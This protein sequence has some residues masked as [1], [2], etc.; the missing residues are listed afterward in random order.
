[1]GQFGWA[2]VVDIEHA[3]FLRNS[4]WQEARDK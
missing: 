4:T 1:M 2:L 3:P